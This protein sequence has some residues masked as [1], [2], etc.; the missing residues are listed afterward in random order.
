MMQKIVCP[1]CYRHRKMHTTDGMDF[2][3][4][5]GEDGKPRLFMDSTSRGG[6]M[7]ALCVEFCPLCGALVGRQE[8]TD[9]E[10]E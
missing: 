8:E 2:W 9:E 3:M 4:E 1:L 7:N 5:W 6:G 10:A